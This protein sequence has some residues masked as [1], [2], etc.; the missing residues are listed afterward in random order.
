MKRF[1]R[2]LAL[3][4]AAVLMLGAAGCGKKNEEQGFSVTKDEKFGGI[5]LSCTEEEF[6][7][8]G[9][10]FGDSVDVEFS[11]GVTLND[12]P[13]YNGYYAKTGVPIVI[14]YPGLDE[15]KVVWAQCGDSWERVG[16]DKDTKASVSV[17]EKGKY[18]DVQSSF[19][20]V[21]ESERDRFPSDEA[22]ANFRALKGGN[23]RKDLV[24]R[25]ASPVDNTYNRAFYADMLA[26]D[27]GIGYVMDLADDEEDIKGYFAKEDFNSE[28][29]KGLYEGG[30]VELMDLSAD[31]QGDVF[32]KA[33]AGALLKASRQ[34]GKVLIHCQEGKD[35][36]GFV[37]FL[38]LALA[39]ASEEEAEADYMETYK[40][41]YDV[42]PDKDP[43]QYRTIADVKFGDFV[44]YIKELAA[45]GSLLDGAEKYLAD[46][47][48]TED[49]I[50][51]IEEWLTE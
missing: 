4:M 8:K 12:L 50:E 37:C 27:A 25:S 19:S 20:L 43:G 26:A 1:K 14:S 24:Y 10:E 28:F 18:L 42:R 6:H 34:G 11:N 9:F 47:G 48:L 44:D 31:F 35:R 21:Y 16:C 29:F 7:E 13:Y 2:I 5:I 33:V 23:I 36:T 51:G 22:F 46:A 41:Y 17:A 38:V 15:V 39:G 45:G 30:M 3:L 49:E 32:K 40:N